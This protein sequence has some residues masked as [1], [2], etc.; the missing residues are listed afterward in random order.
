[1]PFLIWRGHTLFFGRQNYALFSDNITP[2]GGKQ[3]IRQYKKSH[4]H[5]VNPFENN[6]FAPVKEEGSR[7]HTASFFIRTKKTQEAKSPHK[8]F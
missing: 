4:K 6:I 5:F 1:M 2:G 7:T 8:T 3:L